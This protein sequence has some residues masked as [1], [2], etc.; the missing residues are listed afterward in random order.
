[1]NTKS[2]KLE[3]YFSKENALVIDKPKRLPSVIVLSASLLLIIATSFGGYKYYQNVTTKKNIGSGSKIINSPVGGENQ[4]S[5]STIESD[6][7][8]GIQESTTSSSPTTLSPTYIPLP[9]PTSTYSYPATSY[10]SPSATS[11]GSTTTSGSGYDPNYCTGLWNTRTQAIAPKQAEIAAKQ[12][13]ISNLMEKIRGR[14]SGSFVTEAQI[15]AIYSQEKTIL[16]SQLSVL[17]SE[18]NNIKAQYP[19]C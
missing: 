7:L 15:Q 2:T 1:M 16:N 5:P 13:E 11:S 8:N 17:N 9:M 14:T 18:L 6:W 3:E 12:S 19:V 4:S 10:T